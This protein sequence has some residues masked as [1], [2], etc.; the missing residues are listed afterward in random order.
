MWLMPTSSL[1]FSPSVVIDEDGENYCWLVFRSYY[2]DWMF[3]D[4]E[5]MFA[6]VDG[7]RLRVEGTDTYS[8]TTIDRD[9]VM[10][11][12]IAQIPVTPKW[13]EA[14]SKSKDAKIRVIGIDFE[15]TSEMK[16]EIVA[17]LEEM[18]KH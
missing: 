7:E 3:L 2:S 5:V 10:R 11:V 8:D 9:E 6:L 13:L 14:L 12:E 15:V 1:K 18:Q 4:N 16:T 17:L